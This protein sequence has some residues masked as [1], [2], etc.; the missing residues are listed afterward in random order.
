LS[1]AEGG[2]QERRPPWSSRAGRFIGQCAAL[3]TVLRVSRERNQIV[4]L[5]IGIAVVV[6]LTAGAQVWLNTWQGNFYDALARR[7]LAQFGQQLG[8]FGAII[9]VLVVLGVLQAWFREILKIKLREGLTRDLLDQWLRPRAAY[10]LATMGEIGVNPDQRLQEDARHLT[11]LTA[12]L[13]IG[14]FQA[15]VLLFSFVDVLWIL[16]DRVTLPIEGRAVHVPGYMVWCALIYALAGSLLT[17]MVGRPRIRY[18]AEHYGRE[19]ELRSTLVRIN[20]AAEGIALGGGEDAERHLVDAVFVR[21]LE[22]MRRLAN[23]MARL[24]WVTSSYGYVAL[25][26]PIAVASPGYFE[27]T[28]TFGALM[29]VVGA[30]NQVQT[31]LRW[32]VD[33]FPIIADWS[34][35]FLRVMNFYD[36]LLGLD[37]AERARAHI[38]LLEHPEDMLELHDLHLDTG[39]GIAVLAEGDLRIEPGERVQIVGGPGTGRISLFRALAGLWSRGS[40]LLQ[41]PPRDTIMF[42]PQRTYLPPGSLRRVLAYPDP[43]QS[44]S[45]AE[46]AEALERVGLSRLARHLDHAGSWDRDLTFAEQQCLAIVRV[47]LH[48]PLWVIMDATLATLDLA[49]RAALV[50]WFTDRAP[51]T[52]VV[53]IDA[54]PADLPFFA[55]T[56]HLERARAPLPPGES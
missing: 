44:F 51:D 21:V 47:M 54:T 25:V 15:T 26:V 1:V 16:S 6:L 8:L 10:R 20:D 49:G 14:L 48:R 24:T 33:N 42:M 5:G 27:G 41:L 29:M 43:P 3:I 2:L 35:T 17:W 23:N 9:A 46:F 4:S 30:F 50:E 12:D 37:R 7:D 13:G 32:A 28:L 18:N 52:A 40:G 34:A 38:V 19:A 36:A 55:R 11:E 56:L 53:S 22:I 31:S 39:D 45:R